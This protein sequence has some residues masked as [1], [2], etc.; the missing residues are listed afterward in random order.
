MEDEAVRLGIGGF[1]FVERVVQ[2][3][4][5]VRVVGFGPGMGG[6][7][8]A[9][10][11]VVGDFLPELDGLA[12]AAGMSREGQVC[13]VGFCLCGL[14]GGGFGGGGGFGCGVGLVLGGQAAGG[15][16]AG[17]CQAEVTQFQAGGEV[18]GSVGCLGGVGWLGGDGVQGGC[19]GGGVGEQM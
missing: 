18:C 12:D 6:L 14:R 4:V 5:Q 17:E 2:V 9:G 8:A 1:V 15:G 11:G 19:L 3:Q 16:G 13:F 7:G 10:E